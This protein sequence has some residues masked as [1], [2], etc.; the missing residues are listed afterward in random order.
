MISLEVHGEIWPLAQVFTISR[1][2]KTSADV[3]VCTLER[4][5]H[6]GRGESM[7]YPPL[8]RIGTRGRARN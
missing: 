5:G 2:S 8:W 7:P 6:S 1:G 4:D 3:V